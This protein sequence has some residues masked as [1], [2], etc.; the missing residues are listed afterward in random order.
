MGQ[1]KGFYDAEHA[2]YHGPWPQVHLPEQANMN[3]VT[4]LFSPAYYKPEFASKKILIDSETE[5]FVTYGELHET[6]KRVANGLADLGLR[7]GNVVVIL[8][9]NTIYYPIMFLAIVSLGAIVTTMNPLSSKHEIANQ[10]RLSGAQFAITSAQYV[11][12][13]RDYGMV[14]ILY[15]DVGRQR[16]LADLSYTPF[17]ILLAGDS[18]DFSEVQVLQSDTAAL[19]FSSGTTGVTKGVILTH[20]NFIALQAAMN[21]FEEDSRDPASECLAYH[22]LIS[23]VPIPLFHIYGLCTVAG[24]QLRWGCT[25]VV[26]NKF[27]FVGMLHAIE[28][29]RCTSI[30]AVPPIIVALAKQPIVE[31]FDLSS[32][33]MIGCGGA[34]LSKGVIEDFRSRFADIKFS[35]GYG[36]T[37]TVSVICAS[38]HTPNVP[39]APYGSVGYLIPNI[40]A[41]IIEVGTGKS[42]PPRGEGEL[43][44]RGPQV[45]KGYVNDPEA[46]SATIDADGWLHTGDLAYF[47]ETGALFILDRIKELIKYKAYQVAPA[48]IEKVLIQHPDISEA[49]VVPVPDEEAGQLPVACVVLN[50]NGSLTES[51]ITSFVAKE[52]VAPHKKI[53][54]V[55]FLDA[56]PRGES[57][58]IQRRQLARKAAEHIR[59]RT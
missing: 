16:E 40:E 25:N 52:V 15:G 31:K 33:K 50:S 24:L 34:S 32:L 30:P 44:I 42:L 3:L 54:R 37:E 57:G 27:D 17:T 47:T 39:V 21:K 23:L 58:K 12:K 10:M 56:I 18:T 14:L 28:K 49:V 43:C 59:G 26:L 19:M 45:M 38:N 36:M 8:L 46:T 1:Q 13:V 6:V 22:D 5:E 41:K 20:R 29:F 9:N 51:E 11:E 55:F 35:Q 4:Y 7:K 2:T 48:E 53:R